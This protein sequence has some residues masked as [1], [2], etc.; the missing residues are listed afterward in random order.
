[1]SR[2]SLTGIQ[3][4]SSAPEDAQPDRIGLEP[5]LLGRLADRRRGEVGVVGL[6]AAAREADLAAV[7]AAAD[8][9]L[10]Q[11][12]AGVAGLVREQQHEHGRRAR[13]ASG[14]RTGTGV[15][16]GPARRTGVSFAGPSGQRAGQRLEPPR[17]LVEPQFE[18]LR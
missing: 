16:D 5:D 1:M 14:I 6:G 11:Q 3:T 2:K 17:R 13:R 15:R 7:M 9:A 10:G 8:H 12:D 18:P 4:G